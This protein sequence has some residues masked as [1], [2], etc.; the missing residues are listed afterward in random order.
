MSTS[1][2]Y[3]ERIRDENGVRDMWKIIRLGG[4]EISR[5]MSREE[6]RDAD[7]YTLCLQ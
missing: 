5:S 6:V 1:L 2:T 3:L 4:L 7:S